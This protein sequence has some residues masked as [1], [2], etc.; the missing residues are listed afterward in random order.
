[1][2]A[3]P[4]QK[5]ASEEEVPAQTMHSPVAARFS[6]AVHIHVACAR[7]GLRAVPDRAGLVQCTARVN[8]WETVLGTSFH[9][10]DFV[11]FEGEVDGTTARAVG[12]R[13]GLVTGL[14]LDG[15]GPPTACMRVYAEAPL[16]SREE[17]AAKD[18]CRTLVHW[19]LQTDETVEV[20]AET[21]TGRAHVV[22]TPFWENVNAF[23]MGFVVIGHKVESH[24][25]GAG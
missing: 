15:N 22:P 25:T 23:S 1:M 2:R 20:S 11:I 12:S 13:I 3:Q 14:Q 16:H 6:K 4:D 10:Q 5:G 24:S 19:L 18:L 9:M 7:W 8:G 17:Y 21:V